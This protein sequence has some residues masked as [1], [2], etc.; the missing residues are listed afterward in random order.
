MMVSRLV[1][2][3]RHAAIVRETTMISVEA[4]RAS[5]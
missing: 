4:K 2:Q 3:E 5:N 1:C